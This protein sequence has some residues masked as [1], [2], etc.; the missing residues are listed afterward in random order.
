VHEQVEVV[1][2]AEGYWVHPALGGLEGDV[3]FTDSP[4]VAGM[5][6]RFVPLELDNDA[7]AERYF[8]SNDP[9]V[10]DW[11]PTPPGGEG[12]ML[13][14]IYDTEIGPC[15]AFARSS[16]D[17]KAASLKAGWR[18]PDPPAAGYDTPVAV[19]YPDGTVELD[20]LNK[21]KAMY[22]IDDDTLVPVEIDWP[23]IDGYKPSDADWRGIG[24]EPHH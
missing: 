11:T 10:S 3:P 21:E 5:D 4:A 24:F 22:A 17:V 8:E 23:W 14:A 9:K 13:I 19:H 2:D 12:W 16:Q 1:R 6:F 7:I 20:Y 18:L 15:A